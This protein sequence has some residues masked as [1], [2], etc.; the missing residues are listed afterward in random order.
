[1][2]RI[3]KMSLWIA[4]NVFL[5]LIQFVLAV[6]GGLWVA[7]MASLKGA[8]ELAHI[9]VFGDGPS[10]AAMQT[11]NMPQS[12]FTV[13]YNKEFMR[14]LA[15]KFQQLKLCTR[16]TMPE[17]SG[18]TF[19]NF[20]LSPIGPNTTNQQEGTVG[21]PVTVTALFRDI[22]MGQL[23]DYL[24]FSDLAW[25][26]SIS[27][28]MVNYRR[29]LAYRL[30][31][32][33]DNIIMLNFDF[34]RT[35][36]PNTTN[37]DSTTG[38][39][40]P[41]SKAIIEQMP[42]SLQGQNVPPM[43]TG[44]YYGKIHPFFVGDMF[45]LDNSNNSLVDIAK[46]TPE[47]QAKLEELADMEDG[48][49]PI[50]MLELFGTR[51]VPSTNCTQTAVWQGSGLTALSTYCAGQDAMVFVNLPSAQHTDPGVK[52]ANMN[53]RSGEYAFSAFDPPGVIKAGAAYNC[54]YGVG[55]TPD[56]VSR[57][58]IAKAVPQT[59]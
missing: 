8:A 7:G 35:L 49:Q 39:L 55:P 50:R 21:Q 56:S 27:D 38:P 19:R 53:L 33:L 40:Y 31:Y 58:R 51:W 45:A 2:E 3:E 22:V 1:M 52:W 47:G 24:N 15:I 36:D 41:F 9:P 28:D 30:A 29:M 14:W 4:R 18:L 25:M 12:R 10:P 48:D 57:A 34:L 32:S 26:T 11:G 17:K 16:M 42:F 59:T 43:A 6:G 37:Q 54:I 20:M 13:H 23:A 5:P 44:F 46:H